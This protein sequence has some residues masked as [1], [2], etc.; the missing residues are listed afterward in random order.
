M[1]YFVTILAF[2][3]AV[4]GCES[5]KSTMKDSPA[6]QT[7]TKDTIRIAN[8]SLEYEII[9]LE[10]GFDRYLNT[11]P[12]ETY[13]STDFLERKNQFYVGEYNRRVNDPRYSRDL[14]PQT[15][16]Y[17]SRIRYGKEVNYLL[18]IYFQY[19]EKKYNQKLF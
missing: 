15:I 18:F 11:Q 1:N 19:F 13:Y 4:Y 2:M 14:Y 12:P 3:F 10:I 9:I 5:G 8:D 7:G 17:D 6:A 16:D